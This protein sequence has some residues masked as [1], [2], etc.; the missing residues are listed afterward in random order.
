MSNISSCSEYIH[1]LDIDNEPFL[2]V[3]LEMETYNYQNNKRLEFDR[4]RG[5]RDAIPASDL[6]L[7]THTFQTDFKFDA[8]KERTYKVGI[9]AQYQNNFANPE[10]GVRRLIPDYDKIDLGTF[11]IGN[12]T[13]N[14]KTTINTG[15]RY[16]FNY[17]NSKK[18][19]IKSRWTER[20][21]DTKFADLIIGD[22]NTQWLVN[23]KFNFHNISFSAGIT[24]QL[25]DKNSF[26]FNYGLSNR[27]PNASEL[28]SDGLHH[29]AARIELGD[30]AMQQE[31]S[32]RISS[33]YS[34]KT[35]KTIISVEAFLNNI[36]NFIY[37]EPFGTEQTIRGAF[38]VWNYK[39]TNVNL[40]GL[41]FTWQQN[42]SNALIFSNKSS[43]IYGYE[44]ENKRDL[45]DIPAPNFKNSIHYKNEEWH[46]LAISLE[47]ELVLKQNNYPDNNFSVFLP[48]QNSHAIVDISSTPES[49]HLLNLQTDVVFHLSKKTD[50]HISATIS[51][52]LNSSYRD[53]L[54]RLRFFADDL[55][56]NYAL[57]LKINY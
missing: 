46:Q 48:S 18:F 4:R 33:T 56:R 23:P 30:L 11:A 38:P 15:L 21:Y 3:S 25:N 32:N 5:D 51:N 7:Q 57:Q 42:L 36:Q 9:M 37:L 26:L 52:L 24:Y 41:D 29:S 47:S 2:I 13:L 28:F 6:T 55:G 50:L 49:Y 12:F 39:A 40:I 8:K 14:D 53:N 10:T 54:N 31:V 16:D 34:F 1:H 27:A 22:F 20:G 43:L 35:S 19:Y 45:L 17:I 44:T